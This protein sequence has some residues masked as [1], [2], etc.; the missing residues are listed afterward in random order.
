M[1]GGQ[2]LNFGFGHMDMFAWIGAFPATPNA[3]SAE[4]L[5]PDPEA[6]KREMRFIFISC[7]DTDGLLP[8]VSVAANTDGA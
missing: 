6:V 4:L 2:T 1:G 8:P 3:R 5:V 7:G